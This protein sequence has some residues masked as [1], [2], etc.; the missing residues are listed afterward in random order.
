MLL[1]GV[2]IKCDQDASVVFISLFFWVHKNAAV[3][4]RGMLCF[5]GK[6]GGAD[7][8]GGGKASEEGFVAASSPQSHQPPAGQSK[9]ASEPVC[10]AAADDVDRA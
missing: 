7:G 2:Q 4:W 3:A 6:Q 5:T 10:S 8:G 1:K 9:R